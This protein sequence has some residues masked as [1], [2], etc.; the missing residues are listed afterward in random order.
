MKIIITADEKKI[1]SAKVKQ[2]STKLSFY[3]AYKLIWQDIILQENC[4]S[5]VWEKS[6]FLPGNE[7]Y[8]VR[9]ETVNKKSDIRPPIN[10]KELFMV[11]Y[12][13][14]YIWES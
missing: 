5:F 12:I 11:I 7:L 3:T 10:Y 13:I 2:N 9:N 1:S 8:A 14:Y 4:S 6:V